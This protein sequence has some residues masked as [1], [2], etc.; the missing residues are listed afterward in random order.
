MEKEGELLYK[1]NKGAKVAWLCVGEW[2]YVLLF[3]LFG[4]KEIEPFFVMV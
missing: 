2:P 4:E 3:T 1:E